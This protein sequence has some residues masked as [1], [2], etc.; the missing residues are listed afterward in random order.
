MSN[1]IDNQYVNFY[2]IFWRAKPCA[3]C[4]FIRTTIRAAQKSLG[5]ASCL[6]RIPFWIAQGGRF[7]DIHFIDAMTY[8]VD[9]EALRQQM[10]ELKPD[11]VGTTA[12]TPSI[13]QAERILEIAREALPEAA[14]ILAACMQPLC[15]DRSLPKRRGS[16]PSCGAKAR[17]SSSKWRRRS[18]RQ[19]A[20]VAQ[21]H[22]G[23]SLCRKRQGRCN[24][25]APTGEEFRCSRCGLEHSELEKYIYIPLG[26]RVAIPN[27]ARG[28]PFTCS[29]CSQWKFWRDYRIR[30]PKKVCRRD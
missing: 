4:S 29:F 30:D 5:T 24:A 27:M 16:M 8:H 12:I 17:K 11:I 21:R 25:R 22:Q 6:G 18:R 1:I 15:I 7:S 3:S 10:I 20:G 23:V 14:T 19:V 2:Y 28:C 9:E 13:I 26:T